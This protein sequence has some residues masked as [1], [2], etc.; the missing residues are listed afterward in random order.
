M[1][2]EVDA[3]KFDFASDSP[4]TFNMGEM[5][6]VDRSY[7]ALSE[8]IKPLGEYS[9]TTIFYSKGHHRIVEHECPSKRCQSTDIL[10]GLQKCNSGGMT[11]E[12]TCYPLAVAYESKL[13]CL[14]YPGQSNFDPKKPFVP[15]VPFQ[16]DQDSR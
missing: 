5:K 1:T 4:S 12:D 10:K 11:K 9:K 6:E 16:K 3:A 2:C 15:Y 8:A 13:Y 14:L 7:Q